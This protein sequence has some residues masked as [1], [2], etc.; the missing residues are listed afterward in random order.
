VRPAPTALNGSRWG[1]WIP[2][3]LVFP[4]SAPLGEYRNVTLQCY[5]R[6]GWLEDKLSMKE[7]MICGQG[8]D[9]SYACSIGN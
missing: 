5:E 7:E 6:I 2:A 8:F 3:E 1:R 9:V 4:L